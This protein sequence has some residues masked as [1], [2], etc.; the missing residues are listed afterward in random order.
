MP[1]LYSGY[2]LILAADRQIPALTPVLGT[3]RVDVQVWLAARSSWA[4]DAQ[5]A[6]ETARYVSSWR[7]LNGEPA[8]IVWE[9]AGGDLFRLRFADGAE[10]VVDRAGSRVWLTG[11][12]A[13]P[14]G[15]A[16]SY[17]L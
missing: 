11:S 2:G 4:D 7:G 8:L 17:L 13:L 9:Q 10:F 5:G 12:E 15:D 16:D 6:S 3:P 14:P 1:F